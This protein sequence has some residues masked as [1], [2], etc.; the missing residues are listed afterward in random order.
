MSSIFHSSIVH[1]P[2]DINT[3]DGT[4]QLLATIEMHIQINLLT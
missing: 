3:N 2:K 1:N 4:L